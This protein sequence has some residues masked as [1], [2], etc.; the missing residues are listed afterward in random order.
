[1]NFDWSFIVDA[2]IISLALL[3]ATLIRARV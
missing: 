3:V 2:G 1:M